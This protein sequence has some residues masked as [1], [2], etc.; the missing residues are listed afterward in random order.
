[1]AS[2]TDMFP[3]VAAVIATINLLNIF[4]NVIL[5]AYRPKKQRNLARVSVLENSASRKSK[6]ALP[7]PAHREANLTP[8]RVVVPRLQDTVARFRAGTKFS[9]R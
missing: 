9:L 6:H 8:E 4:K 5:Q 3:A 1:M 2:M 7:V